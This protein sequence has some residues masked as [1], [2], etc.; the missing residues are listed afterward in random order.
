MAKKSK[1]DFGG[2]A[3]KCNVVCSDGRTILRDAFKGNDGQQVPLVWNHNHVDVD[4]VLGH[5][6]LENREDGVYAY[7]SLNDTPMGRTAKEL[8]KHGDIRTLSIYA[9]NLKQDG[10]KNVMHGSIREVSL[11]YAPA[12]PGA[13]IDTIIAHSDTA[14]EEA[15]IY[16]DSEE[17]EIPEE[18]QGD[19]Q[20]EGSNDNT[21]EMQH[22]DNT[23]E[24][25][26]NDKTIKDVFDTFNE[27][28][29][30]VVYALIGEAVAEATKGKNAK[31]DS[32][33]KHNAFEGD[34]ENNVQVDAD[35]NEIKTIDSLS[36]SEFAAIVDDAK[37]RVGSMKEAFKQAGI[38]TTITPEKESVLQH[39]I[40]SVETLFPDYHNVDPTPKIVDMKHDWVNVIMS[41]V[42]NI[43]FARIKSQYADLTADEAR[44]KGYIK[45]DQKVEEFISVAKRE[46]DPTTVY[47][48]QKMDRDDVIDITDFDVLAWLKGE[49]RVKLM[50]EIARAILVG[51]G[52]LASSREKINETHIRPII[53]DDP[54]FTI[55]A[56]TYTAATTI[57]N[58]AEH[59][60]DDVVIAMDDYK[61]KGNVTML[62]RRDM[63]TK[64]L[65]LK[66]TM[67]HRLYKSV[68]EI[69]TAMTVN[70]IAPVPSVVMNGKGIYG[71][72]LDLSDYY[73]GK[74][75]KGEVNFFDDFNI[76]YNKYE[77]LIETRMSGALVTPYSALVFKKAS[78]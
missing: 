23:A 68:Q 11:V 5:A 39:G 40:T 1:Y 70:H 28:Q 50:E 35:G 74:A 73:V 33:M 63:L 17:L 44:A 3:T 37:N 30:T 47:K 65:L 54:V 78:E 48:L 59:F 51:D 10:K 75:R 57:D 34:N 24:G 14:D 56:K 55:Q 19:K 20:M 58:D 6:L 9:N 26:S 67:G 41:G 15:V 76:D 77:Y 16:N 69:A 72:A 71:V 66:D 36:H 42:H 52:R 61:G 21:K 43:P 4:R 62:V 64:L 31:E 49:M 46:T 27:E 32:E 18:Q 53:S 7:C 60:I 12:N 25:A 45:G 13:Y 8:V 22:A 29:K 38:D 2:W